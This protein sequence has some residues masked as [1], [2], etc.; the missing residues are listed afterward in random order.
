MSLDV[1]SELAVCQNTFEAG[2]LPRTPLGEL[3]LG[4]ERMQE[5]AKRWQGKW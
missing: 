4:E 1:L 5:K 2:A 3:N